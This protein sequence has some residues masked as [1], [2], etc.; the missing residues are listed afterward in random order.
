MLLTQYAHHAHDNAAPPSGSGH[1]R[2]ALASSSDCTDSEGDDLD[3]E[4]PSGGS[5]GTGGDGSSGSAASDDEG[6]SPAGM[7]SHQH[8]KQGRHMHVVHGAVD[9]YAAAAAAAGSHGYGSSGGGCYAPH[10]GGRQPQLRIKTRLSVGTTNCGSAGTMFSD[11]DDCC[12]TYDFH[13]PAGGEVV[14]GTGVSP[15]PRGPS[16]PGAPDPADNIQ[17]LL[18]EFAAAGA[19]AA[20]AAA[21]AGPDALDDI[22]GASDT[23]AAAVFHGACSYEGAVPKRGLLSSLA[24]AVDEAASPMKKLRIGQGSSPFSNNDEDELPICYADQRGGGASSGG[25]GAVAAAAAV[26]R[27]QQPSLLQ[28]WPGGAAGTAACAAAEPAAVPAIAGDGGAGCGGAGGPL[29]LLEALPCSIRSCLAD[30]AGLYLANDA[31]GLAA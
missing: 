23:D 8:H 31:N 19:A 27:Q 12:E 20:A 16:H 9:V 15:Y 4:T 29:D 17:I 5:E 28:D 11:E 18:E 6:S 14:Y 22:C 1:G 21:G 2:G 24:G 13:F 3:G 10:A 25:G 7:R 30:A 26:V